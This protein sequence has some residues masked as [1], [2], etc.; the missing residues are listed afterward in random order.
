MIITIGFDA[1]SEPIECLVHAGDC[2]ALAR[3]NAGLAMGQPEIRIGLP[4]DDVPL[5][6][7]AIIDRGKVQ[8]ERPDRLNE[9]LRLFQRRGEICLVCSNQV[10]SQTLMIAK[11][12]CQTP[13]SARLPLEQ[14]VGQ[15]N[16]SLGRKEQVRCQNTVTT[17]ERSGLV[18]IARKEIGAGPANVTV[19]L[20]DVI[21]LQNNCWQ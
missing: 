18:V 1:S 15:A 21:Q 7:D 13:Q 10:G 2:I 4:Y 3:Q 20:T 17:H 5:W 9:F 19:F 16:D 12:S 8:P 11:I 14:T 6:T